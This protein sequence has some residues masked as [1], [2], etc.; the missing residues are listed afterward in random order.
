MNAVAEPTKERIAEA[1]KEAMGSTV[2]F[3]AAKP[4][5]ADALP[6]YFREEV[7]QIIDA[8]R[9]NWNVACRMGLSMAGYEGF[10]VEL[11]RA[12]QRAAKRSLK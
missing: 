5:D 1:F 12:A 9:E 6:R 8:A 10:V 2:D 11:K 7:E 4:Y 3:L